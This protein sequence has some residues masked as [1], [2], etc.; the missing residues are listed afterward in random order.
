M[1]AELLASSDRTDGQ[2]HGAVEKVEHVL[3]PGGTQRVAVT[4]FQSQRGEVEETH[5][6]GGDDLLELSI[7]ANFDEPV[8]EH[9][10]GIWE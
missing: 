10:E 8:H 5:R 6:T 1:P 7:F 2:G 9:L 4:F 3:A